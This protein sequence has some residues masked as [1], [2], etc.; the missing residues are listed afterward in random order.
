MLPLLYGLSRS[1]RRYFDGYDIDFVSVLGRSD[2]IVSLIFLDT[3]LVLYDHPTDDTWFSATTLVFDA[4]AKTPKVS[5]NAPTY[6]QYF[7]DEPVGVLGCAT[8]RF[9]CNPDMPDTECV[10]SLHRNKSVFAIERAWPN[11][12]DQDQVYSIFATTYQFSMGKGQPDAFYQLSGAP[13]LLARRTMLKN[14]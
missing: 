13:M 4:I 6:N 7:P 2:A 10:N 3:D 5:P 14:E 11:P 12:Q 9:F 1:Q 8:Q